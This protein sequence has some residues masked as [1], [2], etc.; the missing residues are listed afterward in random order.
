V[1]VCVLF[2]GPPGYGKTLL[3]KM[4][5]MS[6]HLNVCVLYIYIWCMCVFEC[7]LVSV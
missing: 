7:V 3:S 4:G 2:F 5:M 6:V 1:C